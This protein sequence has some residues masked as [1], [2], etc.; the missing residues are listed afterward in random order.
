MDTLQLAKK[1]RC[2]ALEMTS[3]GGSSHIASILSMADIIAVLYGSI[4]KVDP[5]NPTWAG[6]D[7]FIL[8]KGHAGAGIYAALAERGFFPVEK[9][10]THYQDGSDLSGH[11]SHKGIPGVELS[12][13]SLG[14]G[15][16]VA[17]GMAYGAKIEGKSHRVFVVLSDGECDE[18]SN[19]EAILFAAH[20]QLSNL[21]VIVDYNKIQSLKSVSDTLEL[22]PFAEKWRAFGWNVY[23]VNGHHHHE[24]TE[25]FSRLSPSVKPSC[26]IA[27][28]IKG[29][30]VSFMENSVLWHYRTAKG[31]EFDKAKK[32]LNQ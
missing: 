29:K 9:L 10:L 7:R 13:G 18:G 23:E 11:V 3:K 5:K 28:T 24:L 12:T 21:V 4:L 30:G 19:W 14:H 31:D 1:I 17:C 8:S 15:L 22:E 25:V 16:S 26:V 2:H 32:E 27:H 20:H 6:R